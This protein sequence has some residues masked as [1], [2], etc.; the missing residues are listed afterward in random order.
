MGDEQM[1]EWMKMST[2][3]A[4]VGAKICTFDKEFSLLERDVYIFLIYTEVAL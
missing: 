1:N 2:S 4:S 3:W